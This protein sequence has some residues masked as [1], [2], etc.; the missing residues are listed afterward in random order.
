MSFVQIIQVL[1]TASYLQQSVHKQE[2]EN[3][4]FP[5]SV[6]FIL[7]IVVFISLVFLHI[8][9][10]LKTYNFPFSVSIL[11]LNYLIIFRSFFFSLSPIECLS[12]FHLVFLGFYPVPSS[13][14]SFCLS[15]CLYFYVCGRIVQ[16]LDLG[17]ILWVPAEQS[18]W[19]PK[20]YTLGVYPKRSPWVLL[21]WH[22]TIWMVW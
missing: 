11:L 7:V 8:F 2:R 5:S 19:S 17:E 12:P 15:C 22:L 9:S 1:K 13:V 6:F 4:V 16:F 20:L 14:A 21:L 3:I 10:L 18:P